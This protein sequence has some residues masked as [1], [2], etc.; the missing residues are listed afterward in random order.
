ME[1]FN[2]ESLS[3]RKIIDKKNIIFNF[4]NLEILYISMYFSENLKTTIV[5]TQT[6]SINKHVKR[7][8]IRDNVNIQLEFLMASKK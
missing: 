3:K 5:T 6:V 8:H 4:K 7:S 1:K 2:I